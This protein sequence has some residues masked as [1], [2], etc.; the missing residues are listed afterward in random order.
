MNSIVSKVKKSPAIKVPE[1]D[2][3]EETKSFRP[4]LGKG[5]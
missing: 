4:C 2:K 1:A 5:S 3:S